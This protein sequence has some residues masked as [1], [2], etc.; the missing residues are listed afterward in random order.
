LWREQSE[1]DDEDD[2]S[3]STDSGL[4]AF[5]TS[6]GRIKFLAFKEEEAKIRTNLRYQERR[7][8]AKDAKELELANSQ[9]KANE[10]ERA[11]KLV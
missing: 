3:T 1:S 4:R 7:Q 11:M 10:L 2:T 8:A 9:V 6:Q 5:E